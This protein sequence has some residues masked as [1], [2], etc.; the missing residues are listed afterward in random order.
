MEIIRTILTIL[1]GFFGG[2]EL[3]YIVKAYKTREYYKEKRYS[4]KLLLFSVLL[5]ILFIINYIINIIM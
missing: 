5:L 1:V 2:F 3:F 4:D